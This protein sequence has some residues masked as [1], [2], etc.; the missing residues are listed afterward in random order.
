M[1][2]ISHFLLKIGHFVDEW[3]FSSNNSV[4]AFFSVA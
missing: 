1:A 3:S 2:E 4:A